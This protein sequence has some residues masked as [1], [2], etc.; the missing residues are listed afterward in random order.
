MEEDIWFDDTPQTLGSTTIGQYIAS[1]ESNSNLE[2]YEKTKFALNHL[3]GP[4]DLFAKTNNLN[5]HM[6]W[7]VVRKKLHQ[8][9]KSKLTLWQKVKLRRNLVQTSNETV[10]EFF[11]RCVSCQYMICD[12]YGDSVME[13]DIQM[14]FLLGMKKQIYEELTRINHYIDLDTCLHEAER[15]E[16]DKKN[17]KIEASDLVKCEIQEYDDDNDVDEAMTEYIGHDQINLDKFENSLETSEYDYNYPDFDYVG[18]SDEFVENQDNYDQQGHQSKR[19]TRPRRAGDSNNFDY[20]MKS[21]DVSSSDQDDDDDRRHWPKLAKNT[22]DADFEDPKEK[23]LCP[24]RCGSSYQ[25][26]NEKLH[27]KFCKVISEEDIK[28]EEIDESS[29]SYNADQTAGVYTGGRKSSGKSFLKYKKIFKCEFCE[30]SLSSK[31]AYQ[32]HLISFHP[33]KEVFRCS[34]CKS[35]AR[36][37]RDLPDDKALELHNIVYHGELDSKDPTNRVIC[38][39]CK[40]SY[41]KSQ[42]SEHIKSEHYGKKNFM[43]EQCPKCFRTKSLLEKHI[44]LRHLKNKIYE[45]TQCDDGLKFPSYASYQTHR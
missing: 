1:I 33:G 16:K 39:F 3:K 14:N 26:M 18:H 5:E 41:A 4:A 36:F 32:R 25:R 31:H 2:N 35:N 15:L 12:D 43:C 27:L 45:C 44:E 22:D 9:F 28:K 30:L 20:E 40:I 19:P 42:I 37:A 11:E 6:E 38:P 21:D 13:R 7:S 8:R 23:I 10:K 29:C 17:I 24:R 34:I